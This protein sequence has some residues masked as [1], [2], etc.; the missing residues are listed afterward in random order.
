[1]EYVV[2]DATNPI[3]NGPRI[4]AH[5]CND[6]KKWGKGFTYALSLRWKVPEKAYRAWSALKTP[7]A[8][9]LGLVQFVA[10]D[11]DIMVA[12]M[13]AQHGIRTDDGPPPIRYDALEKCL[14]KVAT[15]ASN[16]KAS[17][18]MPRIG[19]GLSG[20][21]WKEIV[22]IVERVFSSHNVSVYIYDL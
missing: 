1:M 22:K 18:H 8:F 15:F 9:G 13:V 11:Q 3:G 16:K 21:D 5:V 4:I 14:E 19:A 20:G 17:V 2:G 10:V 7:H 6:A 12:N